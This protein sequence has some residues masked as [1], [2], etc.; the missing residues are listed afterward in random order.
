MAVLTASGGQVMPGARRLWTDFMGTMVASKKGGGA[1]TGATGDENEMIIG[2]YGDVPAVGLEWH[3]LG[4]QTIL[5]PKKTAVGLDVS[6]DQTA[7]DGL[8]IT[9]GIF[10][11]ANH[12]GSFKVGTDP[13]FYFKLR[14]KLA[15]VD[16][17]DDCAV[18][19]RKAEAYQANIDDYDEM[20]ALNVISGNIKLETILNGGATTTSETL[21]TWAD[22]ET[23]TLKVFV[24]A[25]GLVSYQIDDD[26]AVETTFS[27]DDGE[28]VIPFFYF[29]HDTNVCDTVELIEWD[30]GLQ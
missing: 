17:T 2:G 4:T 25:D 8:E 7:N 23:H 11:R 18:G 26:A 12:P 3:V 27:F 20:A 13:A 29:L 21:D 22:G 10:Y 19:F 15:D 1:P 16:G 6:M 28:E 24:N 5:S 30:C 9:P 14:F